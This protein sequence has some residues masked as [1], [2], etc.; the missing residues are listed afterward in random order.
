LQLTADENCVRLDGTD[1]PEFDQWR[2]VDFWYPLEH[3]V[4]F[5]RGVYERALHHLA[6]AARRLID[7][8][9]AP[10]VPQS[11]APQRAMTG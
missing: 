8:P 9:Q 4:A 10:L 7:I 3:V 6:P 2:W 11:V 1:R 5:K